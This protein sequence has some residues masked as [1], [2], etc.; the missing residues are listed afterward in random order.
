[1]VYFPAPPEPVFCL[2]P[3]TNAVSAFTKAATAAERDAF[4]VIVLEPGQS[5]AGT[6]LL[7]PF[8]A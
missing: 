4:G 8:Q 2:E 5:A 3:Q 1:M 6:F 7:E